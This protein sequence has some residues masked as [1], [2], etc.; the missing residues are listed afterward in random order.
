MAQGVLLDTQAFLS[1]YLGD[2]LP[3][4]ATRA[5]LQ[6]DRYLS[7]AS[8]WEVAI[9]SAKGKLPPISE[10]HVTEAARDLVVTILPITP[11][12]VYR[13]FSLPLHHRDPFD[14]IIIATALTEQLPLI[15]G[16]RD[17]AKY[18]GLQLIWK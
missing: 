9:K 12:H 8:L 3:K 17:F 1:A 7:A 10:Q 2:P 4:K 15:S 11:Q 14:R 16:D 6:N 13:V 18:R 5:I